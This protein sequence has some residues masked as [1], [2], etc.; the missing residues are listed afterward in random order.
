MGRDLPGISGSHGALTP[1][2]ATLRTDGGARGNPGPAGAGFV[3][4]A[5]DG[6]IMAEGGR[7]LGET[8]NNVAEYEA[9]IWGLETAKG[10]G[11]RCVLVLSDSELVV[12]QVT[13][14][15]RVKHANMRPLFVRAM[16]LL[17]QFEAYEMRH[18]PRAENAEADRLV[19]EAIDV[20]GPVGDAIETLG[21]PDQPALFD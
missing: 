2:M 18:V 10:L 7:F 11:V 1:E 14:V 12:R 16:Q 6:S 20:R 21:E 17:R 19:N 15:Y 4:E 8:T 3:L 5:A 13:G 9:L